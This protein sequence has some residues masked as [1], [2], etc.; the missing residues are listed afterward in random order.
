MKSLSYIIFFTCIVSL[1][2]G[3]AQVPVFVPEEWSGNATLVYTVKEGS[4]FFTEL[5]HEARI[6]K[7]HGTATTNYKMRIQNTESEE[8][9]SSQGSG[10]TSLNIN[11]DLPNYSF[12]LPTPASAGK[13]SRTIKNGGTETYTIGEE[14]SAIM[15]DNQKLGKNM[16]VLSG[17]FEEN[18]TKDGSTST[19]TITWNFSRKP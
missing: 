18:S 6:S 9:G 19:L 3:Y 1:S 13:A 16:N 11:F 4:K 15:V 5:R 17:K 12:S 8:T 14:E 2:H 10:P 7:G